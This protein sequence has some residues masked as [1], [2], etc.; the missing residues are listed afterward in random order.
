MTCNH[1][2][3]PLQVHPSDL[4]GYLEGQRRLITALSGNCQMCEFERLYS[5]RAS[6]TPN[7]HQRRREAALSRRSR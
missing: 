3:A 2:R 6:A 4:R 5:S 1:V 7:R